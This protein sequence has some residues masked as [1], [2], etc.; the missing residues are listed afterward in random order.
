MEMQLLPVPSVSAA[1]AAKIQLPKEK[2]PALEAEPGA[3]FLLPQLM[4]GMC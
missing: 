4:S 1:E 2:D 3:M